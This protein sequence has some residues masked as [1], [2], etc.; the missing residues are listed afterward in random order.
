MYDCCRELLEALQS[1]LS[2]PHEFGM[3]F[4][5][6][7]FRTQYTIYC[8][9]YS[10]G[11]KLLEKALHEDQSLKEFIEVCKLISNAQLLVSCL[12]F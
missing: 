12:C 2:D 4:V 10:K 8:T 7:D 5:Q 6:W 3:V 1:T 9:G 11:N